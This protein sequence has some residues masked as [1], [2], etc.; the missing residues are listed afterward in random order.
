MQANGTFEVSLNPESTV[1]SFSSPAQF[2]RMSIDKTFSGDLTGTSLGEM[3]N[4]RSAESA[5]A[6]Y[7]AIEQ[8]QGSLGGHTGGFVLQHYG[9]MTKDAQHLTL[10]ILPDSGTEGL[11]GIQGSMTIDIRDGRHFYQLNYDIEAG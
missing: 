8:F 2:G 7:V 1:H 3:L 11:T 5:S 10:E 4:C 9:V 6:G